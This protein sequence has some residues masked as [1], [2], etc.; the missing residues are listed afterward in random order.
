M[1]SHGVKFM[2][3]QTI[4]NINE[5]EKFTYKEVNG[6]NNVKHVQQPF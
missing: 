2:E 3:D 4:E 5:W 6:M 1:R